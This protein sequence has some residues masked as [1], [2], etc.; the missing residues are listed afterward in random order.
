MGQ[1]HGFV[2]F[3]VIV[4]IAAILFTVVTSLSPLAIHTLE[5]PK[6]DFPASK[7]DFG[8]WVNYYRLLGLGPTSSGSASRIDALS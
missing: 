4:G 8:G 3:L 6:P 2:A 1:L 7:P 5:Q